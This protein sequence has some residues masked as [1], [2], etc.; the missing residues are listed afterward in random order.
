[1]KFEFLDD[2]EDDVDSVGFDEEV[3]EVLCV[4]LEARGSSEFS[5]EFAFG[6]LFDSWAGEIVEHLGV[7]EEFFDF[8]DVCSG[9]VEGVVGFG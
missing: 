9:G 3:E 5:N 8:V 4:W 7:G 1:M 6:G 2:V